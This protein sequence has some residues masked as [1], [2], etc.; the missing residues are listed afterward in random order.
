MKLPN[1]L[2]VV[3]S[4]PGGFGM[5]VL[6]TPFYRLYNGMDSGIGFFWF[7]FA[8]FLLGPSVYLVMQG[9]QIEKEH[10]AKRAAQEKERQR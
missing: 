6:L 10:E 9:Q 7:F 3:A 8:C 5:L 4:L 1:P 2:E